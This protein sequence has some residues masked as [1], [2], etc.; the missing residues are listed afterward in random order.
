MVKKTF[1]RKQIIV[2]SEILAQVRVIYARVLFN[3]V[4]PHFFPR[5][6]ATLKHTGVLRYKKENKIT[7]INSLIIFLPTTNCSY[8]L[9]I[10][11]LFAIRFLLK[12][13]PIFR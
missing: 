7:K 9:F 10:G 5:F 13:W 11:V 8:Y 2:I 1:Q 6:E 12:L 4:L 3:V